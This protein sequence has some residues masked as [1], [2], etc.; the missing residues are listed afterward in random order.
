MVAAIRTGGDEREWMAIRWRPGG[1]FAELERVLFRC[2]LAA[3]SP[4][5]VADTPK[6]YIERLGIAVSGAFC[7]RGGRVGGS[8][9]VFDPLVEIARSH[10]ANVRRNI[11]IGAD[12]P[13]EMH[14]LI[15]AEFIR[16]I[17][18]RNAFG[19]IAQAAV[20]CPEIAALR[21]L[22]SRPDAIVPVVTVGE[23]SSRPADDGGTQRAHGVNERLA[24]SLHVGNGGVLAYPDAVIYDAADMLGEVPVEQG[25]DGSVGF[26]QQNGD[27]GVGRSRRPCGNQAGWN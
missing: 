6:S 20:R 9:A 14:E 4:A 17:L 11:R 23:T 3:A 24:N 1:E 10:T 18:G 26:I 27:G 7:A 25:A 8:V 19:K 2:H 13:A 16:V 22:S 15:R 21:P 5:F 12:Q